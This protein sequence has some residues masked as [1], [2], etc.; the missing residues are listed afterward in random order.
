MR[1]IALWLAAGLYPGWWR[2]RYG[3]ELDALIEDADVSFLDLFGVVRSALEMRM[4]TNNTPRI[5]ELTSRD[6]P[7]GYELETAV[8]Y[9]REDGTKILVRQFYR[10][11]DLGDSYVM[12]SH[13][14]RGSE[15]AQTILV[16]GKKGEVAGDFRSDQTEMFVLNAD[17]T[18]RRTEQTVLTSLKYAAYSE[19][20]REK[21]R[22][23]MKSGLT[24]DEIHR[25][26]VTL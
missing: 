22:E 26:I 3:S 8:E 23:G 21:Y 10:E 6:I 25:R 17:G 20:L 5:A 14:S 2:L 9:P 15:P 16:S 7:H 13:S 18:V 12:L 24:P 4:T 11:V 19:R 1:R